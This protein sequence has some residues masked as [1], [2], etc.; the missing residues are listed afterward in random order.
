MPIATEQDPFVVQCPW[1]GLVVDPKVAEDVLK[2]FM[3]NDF[4]AMNQKTI[5]CEKCHAELR[6]CVK[7]VTYRV[8]QLVGKGPLASV[9][10]EAGR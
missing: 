1:C 7:S 8:A 3:I 10:V 2:K 6:L 5:A 9:R 4:G